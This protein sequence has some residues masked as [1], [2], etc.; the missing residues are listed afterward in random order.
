MNTKLSTLPPQGLIPTGI[1]PETLL[2]KAIETG[3]SVDTIE[4][5]LALRERL[6]A[7]AS[8]QAYRQAR[9]AVQR[10]APKILKTQSVKDK[11]GKER[12]KYATLE[13]ITDVYKPLLVRNGFSYRYDTDAV[14]GAVTVIMTISHIGGH[15]ETNRFRVPIDPGAFMS[16]PQKYE[17]AMSFAQRICFRNGFGIITGQNDTNTEP[18]N[19]DIGTIR[20]HENEPDRISSNSNEHRHLEARISELGLDRDRVKTW[21]KRRWDVEHFPDLSPSQYRELLRK[22]PEFAEKSKSSKT[23]SSDNAEGDRL[24]EPVPVPIDSADPGEGDTE[25]MEA[26]DPEASFIDKGDA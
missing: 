3:Q 9:L 17:S 16:E 10:E 6:Q 21:C 22:L 23:P 11:Y 12:Y 18:V 14:S 15:D 4:R 19:G 13:Q 8:A 24:R 25:D 26:I 2:L 7:E 20:N 5:L 1:N